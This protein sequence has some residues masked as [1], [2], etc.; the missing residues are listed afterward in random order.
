MTAKKIGTGEKLLTKRFK[1]FF[2]HNK[3]EVGALFVTGVDTV[4]FLTTKIQQAVFADGMG[5]S[6]VM[7]DKA[8][9]G[10]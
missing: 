5:M 2:F 4:G 7:V 8:A 10:Y 1:P 9:V 3:R 6:I